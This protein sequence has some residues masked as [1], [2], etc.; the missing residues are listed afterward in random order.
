MLRDRVT[1][2]WTSCPSVKTR[3]VEF[4]VVSINGK[5]FPS[6]VFLCLIRHV[7]DSEEKES[8]AEAQRTRSFPLRTPRSPRAPIPSACARRSMFS[9]LAYFTTRW[10]RGYISP[11]FSNL[12]NM[13]DQKFKSSNILWFED[14]LG[15]QDV[16]DGKVF[17][18]IS[19]VFSC[20]ITPCCAAGLLGSSC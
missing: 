20:L 4:G 17:G 11:G 8:H 13:E 18:K 14:L 12:W 5:K 7:I 6:Y 10:C 16:G 1:V 2:G 19:L 9:T 15:P 3:I